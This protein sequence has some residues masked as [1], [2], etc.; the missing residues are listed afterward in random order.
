MFA[1]NVEIA[2]KMHAQLVVVYLTKYAIYSAGSGLKLFK[3]QISS[4]LC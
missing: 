1:S 4:K 2:G 3:K